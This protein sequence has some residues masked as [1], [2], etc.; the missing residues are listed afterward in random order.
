MDCWRAIRGMRLHS[1]QKVG[2]ISC[3]V[4]SR[5]IIPFIPLVTGYLFVYRT[6][7]TVVV[8]FILFDPISPKQRVS[9]KRL[10]TYRKVTV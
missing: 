7:I 9:Q 10:A 3:S 2:P 4:Y 6:Y 8:I 5:L 1:P